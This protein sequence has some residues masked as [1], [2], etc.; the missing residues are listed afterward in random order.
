MHRVK[1]HA[2]SSRCILINTPMDRSGRMKG[3]ANDGKHMGN[4][5]RIG[6]DYIVAGCIGDSFNVGREELMWSALE[7]NCLLA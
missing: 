7:T 3:M 2:H 4:A 1:N 6:A 5:C